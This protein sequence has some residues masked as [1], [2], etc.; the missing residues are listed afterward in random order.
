[1]ERYLKML[2]FLPIPDITAVVQEHQKDPS[3]RVAQH[4]LAVEFVSLV[5]G[6]GAAEEA[7]QQHKGIFGREGV[8]KPRARLAWQEGSDM[9]IKLPRSA[10]IGVTFPRVLHSA[11]LARSVSEGHRMVQAQGAYA[12]AKPQQPGDMGHDVTWT[13]IK[14][15]DPLDTEKYLL[16]GDVLMLR[17]GKW[18]V[19]IIHLID[20][21]EFERQGLTLPGTMKSE[22]KVQQEIN[23]VR[24]ESAGKTTK[25]KDD[26]LEV[27]PSRSSGLRRP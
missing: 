12:G 16:D 5:H 10:V 23:Q 1:V 8:K 24:R 7:E 21:A 27:L 15:F 26:E 20:D 19:R 6:R 9:N 4:L 25:R 3:K 14:T 2:T 22:T 18:K 11:G 13:P 17:H